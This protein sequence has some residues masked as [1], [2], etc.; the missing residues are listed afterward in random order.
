MPAARPLAALFGL[1]LTG[2]A[3][4]P[5]LAHHSTAMYDSAHPMTLSGTV[6]EFNWTNP[7]IS[8]E[9]YVDGKAGEAGKVWTLEASSTGVMTRAGWNKHT[10][11]PGD[12]ITVLFSPQRDGSAGGGLTSLTLPDGKVITWN[13]VK[14]GA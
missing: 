1:L 3:A 4:T 2:V 8:V 12:K 13:F 11:N 10:V 7:H 14:P 5:S 6:K 9:L